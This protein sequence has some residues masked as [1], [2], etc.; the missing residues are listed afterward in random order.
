M[1][2]LVISSLTISYAHSGRTD[3]A[4]GHKDKNNKSG[5]GSYHYHCGGYPAHLHE[6]G[7]CPYTSKGKPSQSNETEKFIETIKPVVPTIKEEQKEIVAE[8]IEE[9]KPK[10][11]FIICVK[12]TINYEQIE[13]EKQKLEQIKVEDEIINDKENTEPKRANTFEK[14]DN[15]DINEGENGGAA[16][17]LGTMLALGGAGY[18]AYKKFN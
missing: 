3:G 13:Q 1:G 14:E 11:E 10:Q 2:V 15:T 7:Y 16:S 6:N 5:L 9:E 17:V 12:Q 18:F 8:V 4:G